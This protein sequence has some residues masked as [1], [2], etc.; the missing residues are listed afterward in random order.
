MRNKLCREKTAGKIR[1]CGTSEPQLFYFQSLRPPL[2]Q[3]LKTYNLGVMSGC[4][5]VESFALLWRRVPFLHS[6]GRQS[7]AEYRA[8]PP[9]RNKPFIDFRKYN[10]RL[11]KA[12][13]FRYL[14]V[15][16]FHFIIY[17]KSLLRFSYN[18]T[19]F[20]FYTFP[21]RQPISRP[22]RADFSFS[23]DF[24]KPP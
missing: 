5:L 4:R 16:S 13:F 10:S 19:F 21:S 15:F 23:F 1:S 17:R 22:E 8:A 24:P 12:G 18:I 14:F 20:S 2:D 9:G 6:V 3:I 11:K 7:T